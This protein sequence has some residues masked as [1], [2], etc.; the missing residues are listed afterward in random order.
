MQLMI[1]NSQ[2]W[3]A[4][5]KVWLILYI[6][7]SY[8]F[9]FEF[10]I[11]DSLISSLENHQNYTKQLRNHFDQEVKR[12]KEKSKTQ[13]EKEPKNSAGKLLKWLNSLLKRL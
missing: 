12:I 8:F 9:A 6:T 2:L 11:S 5:L 1:T 7:Q 3:S 4:Y 13:I 10:E